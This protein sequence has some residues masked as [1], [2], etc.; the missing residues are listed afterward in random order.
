V[1]RPEQ[2]CAVVARVCLVVSGIAVSVALAGQAPPVFKV[3][4]WN[5]RSG[6]GLRAL[7]GGLGPMFSHQTHNCTDPTQPMNAWGWGLPQRALRDAVGSDPAVIALGLQEAWACGRPS[8]VRD[9]LGWAYASHDL[10][11]TALLARY[12][13]RGDLFTQRIATRG[14]DGTEDQYLFGADVCTDSSCTGT[15][16]TYTV[17]FAGLDEAQ[18]AIQTRNTIAAIEAQPS[19]AASIVV[20]DFNNYQKDLVVKPCGTTLEI[21]PGLA[22]WAEHG[23]V[24]AWP[25]LRPTEDGDTGMWNRNGCGAPNGGLFKRIDYVMARGYTPATIDRW[26]MIDPGVED[27]PSDHAGIVATLSAG[28]IAPPQA[29][30]PARRSEIVIWPGRQATIVGSRWRI[31]DDAS[32]AGG[33]ALINVDLGE[34]KRGVALPTPAS[35]VDV[36]F[37]AD[38]NTAY[39]LWIRG[40]AK[41]D[42]WT[43]DSLFVQFSD[44]IDAA[45][46]PI[47]RIGSASSTW[48]SLEELVN[49]G[50]RGWGWQDNGFGSLD[51]A[52][53]SIRFATTGPHTLR[54]Q[55]REDGIAVDQI[56]LSA[57]KYATERPGAQRDDTNILDERR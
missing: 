19:A 50:E 52:G 20:G 8:N 46:Q 2:E 44:A 47:F 22:A 14:I 39:R 54:L 33:R 57:A 42:L 48:W 30:V 4:S 10:N 51:A 9:V 25:F 32:A 15:V 40:K 3:A 5:I 41:A 56:V 6:M 17:H 18:L 21:S 24:D 23:F 27:A 31:V 34:P 53:P 29:P 26:A 43:N 45:G 37:L 1:T 11:G 36:T 55:Q 7:S 49:Q 38:A 28:S 13:I 35:Y 12:G 16:R